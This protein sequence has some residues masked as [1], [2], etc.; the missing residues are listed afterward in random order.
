MSTEPDLFVNTADLR[1]LTGFA[2]CSKQIEWLKANA[3]PH[4]V[5]GRGRPK[6]ARAFIEGRKEVTQD[7]PATGWAPRV[8]KRA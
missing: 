8:L 6:V 5:N 2:K 7:K 4:F 3:V 1:E